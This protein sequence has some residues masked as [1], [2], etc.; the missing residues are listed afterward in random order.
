MLKNQRLTSSGSFRLTYR[1]CL[2]RSLLTDLTTESG[3]SWLKQRLIVC[4][5]S[6]TEW[7]VLNVATPILIRTYKFRTANKI[8]PQLCSF[9]LSEPLTQLFGT[10]FEKHWRKWVQNSP[11]VGTEY[12]FR[13]REMIPHLMNTRVL[14]PI[15]RRTFLGHRHRRIA[16]CHLRIK[17]IL[18]LPSLPPFGL[19]FRLPCT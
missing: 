6:V 11:A 17:R 8:L 2:Q 7:L 12:I 1:L 18:P 14:S 4:V 10:L 9:R 15:G 16:A 13:I 5:L 3:S 19:D